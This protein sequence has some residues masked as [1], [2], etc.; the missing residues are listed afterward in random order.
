M[1]PCDKIW[2]FISVSN[3]T[4]ATLRPSQYIVS[5]RSKMLVCS[6]IDNVHL[7]AKVVFTKFIPTVFP[8][9]INTTLWRDILGFVA[10]C[11]S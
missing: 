8:V 3:N 9:V 1:L 10:S 6:V 4:E 2:L 7:L 5:Q 11:S